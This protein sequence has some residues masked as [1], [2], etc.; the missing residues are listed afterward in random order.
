M[1]GDVLDHDDSVIDQ[2]ADREDQ[3]EQA[4]AIDRVAH[5]F[6]GE[7]RQQDRG[8]DHHQRHQRLAPADRERDQHDDRDRGEPEVKQQLVGLVVGGLAVVAG[9]LDLRVIGGSATALQ[10]LEPVR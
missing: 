6:G 4:D 8:R 10:R 5:Q 9:D 3:R 2:D 7:Q 1:A